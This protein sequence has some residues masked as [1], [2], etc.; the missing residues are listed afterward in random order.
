MT[1]LFEDKARTATISATNATLEYP[2]SNLSDV[3][4]NR[5]FVG[6]GLTSVVTLNYGSNVP[7][8]SLILAYC[9]CAFVLVQIY[10]AANAL[11]YIHNSRIAGRL[12]HNGIVRA[13]I[14]AFAALSAELFNKTHLR[15]SR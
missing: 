11:V 12:D 1:I 4:L 10:N 8:D 15:F 9:N 6:S 2:A 3:F 7:I 14:Q 5:P 13:G